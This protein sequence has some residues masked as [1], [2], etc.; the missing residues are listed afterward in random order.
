MRQRHSMAA[1]LGSILGDVWTW[2]QSQNKWYSNDNVR[3]VE[4]DKQQPQKTYVLIC[5]PAGGDPQEVQRFTKF[6]LLRTLE[7]KQ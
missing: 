4:L 1:M 5:H 6:D 3:Y 7:R 2:D